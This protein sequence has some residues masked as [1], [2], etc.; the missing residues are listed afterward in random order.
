MHLR[1]LL[2]PAAGAI[3]VAALTVAPAQAATYAV[4]ITA[5]KTNADVGTRF[6]VSGKVTG[7]S[8]AS[9]SIAIQRRTGSAAWR[10]LTT[11]K[12]TSKGTYRRAITVRQ[13]GAQQYRVVA[14]ASRS[15]KRGASQAVTVTG[16][17]W[18]D[19]YDESYLSSGGI[20]TRG[21]YGQ[22]NGRTPPAHTFTMAGGSTRIYWNLGSLCDSVHASVE[23]PNHGPTSESFTIGR[24]GDD[25]VFTLTAGQSRSLDWDS[26]G[27]YSFTVNHTNGSTSGNYVALLTPKA[28]CSAAR[29]PLAYD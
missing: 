26:T 14:P 1:T 3:V 16:W 23:V 4:S 22:L 17:T 29:L 19:L 20:L 2:V 27:A 15:T 8:S 18:L 5:S 7:K 11:V 25:D 12:T 13:A 6:T 21:Y 10:T 24:G 28:H 9:K